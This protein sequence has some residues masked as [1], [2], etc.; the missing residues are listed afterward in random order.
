LNIGGREARLRLSCRPDRRPFT[1]SGNGGDLL[2]LR[3][4]GT[5]ADNESIAS[6]ALPDLYVE[7]SW[8]ATPP[9]HRRLTSTTN[10][11]GKGIHVWTPRHSPAA[12]GVGVGLE[13]AA[14]AELP[15]P[16]EPLR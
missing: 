3:A 13:S 15:A 10:G 7:Q 14:L 1:L 12:H 5:D 6:L 2:V 16:K 8:R 4:S 11:N 9:A